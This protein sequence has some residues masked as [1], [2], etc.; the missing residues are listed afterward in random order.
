MSLS[1]KAISGVSLLALSAALPLALSL[2]AEK[3]IGEALAIAGGTARSIHVSA[4]SGTVTIDG[5]HL[6]DRLSIER[7]NAPAAM[8]GLIAPA[9][10]Q[11]GAY[12]LEGLKFGTDEAGV[13][14][15]RIEV[16]GASVDKDALTAL[17]KA[18]AGLPDRLKT[19]SAKQI[20]APEIT[21]RIVQKQNKG[22]TE[23]TLKNVIADDLTNGRLQRL[24][25]GESPYISDAPGM[26]QDG[27]ILGTDIR[28]LDLGQI[29]RVWYGKAGADEK[30]AAL[31]ESY[32]M[33]GMTSRTSGAVTM[34]M[35]FGKLVGNAIRMR[36]LKDASISDL[37]ADFIAMSPQQMSGGK[38]ASPEE[39]ARMAKTF[40]AFA[41]LMDSFEDD[42]TV[43]EN[44]QMKVG[45]GGK[46]ATFSIAK[47]GGTYGNGKLPASFM[48]SDINM[49]GG[50]VTA[51][52][53]QFG[54]TN[55]SYAPTLRGVAAMME[56]PDFKG[57][58]IDVRSMLPRI[59]QIVIKGFEVDAPDPKSPKGVKPER[60]N[61][62]LGQFLID[63]K[64]EV[65][66]I[67]TD[68]TFGVDNLALKL[69]QNSSEE[70]IK[71]LKALGYSALDM[72]AKLAAR[73][74][75]PAREIAI[76]DLSVSGAGMGSAR[77]SGTLGNI[78]REAIE[79][80][81]SMALVAF[82]GAT[83]KSLSLKVDNAGLAEKAL[84]FQARQQGRKPE[85]LKTELG[86]MAQM[87][88]PM[89]LGN[90]DE[91]KAIAGALAKF[92]VRNKSLAIDLTAKNAG[93]LG[94]PDVM[95]VGNPADALKLVTVK[96]SATD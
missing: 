44:I 86:G 33:A 62:K 16:T 48:L 60:I 71:F 55:F 50:D 75:E 96:A 35:N 14:I 91:A 17:F 13:S 37:I 9:L 78:G 76:T 39:R 30:P 87:A 45:E 85:E 52:L 25:I 3:T 34:E 66:G 31:Y 83:A 46:D 61:L 43:G 28:G 53:A 20:R 70:G 49:K 80:D 84:A 5:I 4:L 81:Q 40:K 12:T 23:Y 38:D 65:K 2:H 64:N 19:L 69:P 32:T 67:P 11:S 59:G 88:I 6:G 10:A 21:A 54:I 18:D 82:M 68:I 58:N 92:A 42:G 1:R 89:M 47:F 90:S 27:T 56:K 22:R 79:A 51:R 29:A 24:A 7:I 73:W 72:S 94:L 26:K 95:A 77:L 93:G 36:P 57:D 41:D 74:D 15:P 63:T 8:T